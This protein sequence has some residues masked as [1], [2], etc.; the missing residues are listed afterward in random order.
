MHNGSQK[1]LSE[2]TPNPQQYKSIMGYSS[3]KTNHYVRFYDKNKLYPPISKMIICIAFMALIRKKPSIR[4]QLNWH[5]PAYK[6]KIRNPYMILFMKSFANMARI[7][8]TN[9]HAA[10]NWRSLRQVPIFSFGGSRGV[11]HWHIVLNK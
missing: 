9:W 3:P 6:I 5:H 8:T 2:S 11:G 7:S 10:N 1:Q 4:H